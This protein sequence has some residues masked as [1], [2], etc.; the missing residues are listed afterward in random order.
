MPMGADMAEGLAGELC[1]LAGTIRDIEGKP[2]A[3]ARLDLWQADG[4][5]MYESQLGKEEPFLRAI[6]RTGP[7]G[8]YAIRTIAPPGYSIPM[9]GTVGDLLKQTDISHYRPA[10]IHF[11]ITAPGYHPL[12]THIFRKGTKLH[13]LGHRFRREGKNLLLNSSSIRQGKLP[14]GETSASSFVVVNYDFVLQ[15][16]G[17][18]E[19]FREKYG[20]SSF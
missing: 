16:G 12:V 11:F 13:R 8:K 4:D 17:R 6:F 20:T 3:G 18:I 9:D 2:V 5:G 15:R 7:D 14:T 10:H 1:F 19:R